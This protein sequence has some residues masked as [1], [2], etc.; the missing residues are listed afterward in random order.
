MSTPPVAYNVDAKTESFE[1]NEKDLSQ[2][3]AWQQLINCGSLSYYLYSRYF[4]YLVF[5]FGAEFY[6]LCTLFFMFFALS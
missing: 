6:V 3:P 2:I 5:E 4:Y 1:F